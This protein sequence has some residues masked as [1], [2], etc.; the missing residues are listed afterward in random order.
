MATIKIGIKIIS[1]LKSFVSLTAGNAELLNCFRKS[2]KDFTRIRKLPVER[3]VLLIVKLC[4]KTLSVELETFFEELGY[5][6]TCSVSAFTQQR[7]KLGAS[8]FLWWNKVLVNSYYH[9]AAPDDISRWKGFR[10]VAA[11][12]SN[13]SLVNT[14]VLNNYF[15]GA[16]NQHCHFVQAKTFITMTY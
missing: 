10:V 6:H 7:A 14:P 11:D 2:E 5:H 9:Y 3:L 16:S 13:V 12:G 8:F 1:E 4:K 15:G